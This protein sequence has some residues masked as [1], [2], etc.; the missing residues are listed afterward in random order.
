MQEFSDLIRQADWVAYVLGCFSVMNFGIFWYVYFRIQW[1]SKFLR[2][3]PAHSDREEYWEEIS[4]PLELGISWIATFAGLSTLVGLFGTV[5]GIRK[6]FQEM[7]ISGEVGIQVF[8]G[9]VSF[10]LSTTILGLG[11]AILSYVLHQICRTQLSTLE[12]DFF[13]KDK[14]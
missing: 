14:L 4:H 6:S 11:I 9:G 2:E 1:L 7:Q 12:K 10:A 5:I 13:K 3:L 8:A